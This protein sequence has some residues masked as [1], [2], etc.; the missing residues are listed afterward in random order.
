MIDHYKVLEV[1]RNATQDEIKK[2][3]R[4]LALKFHP[5]KFPEIV[6]LNMLKAKTHLSE[7]ERDQLIQLKKKFKE[8][9]EKFKKISEAFEVLSDPEKKAS[10]IMEMILVNKLMMD[11]HHGNNKS[12][13]KDT[14]KIKIQ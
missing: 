13:R 14:K 7:A 12:Q 1:E 9:E 10:T 11:T 8:C 6:D 2:A 3:Y 5:D 4:K